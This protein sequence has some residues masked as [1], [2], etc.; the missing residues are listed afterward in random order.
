MDTAGNFIINV[1]KIRDRGKQAAKAHQELVGG[2]L[3]TSEKN[4]KRAFL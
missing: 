4:E 2:N 1:K 3:D